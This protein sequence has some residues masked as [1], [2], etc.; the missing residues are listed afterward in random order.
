MNNIANI[1]AV[2]KVELDSELVGY[3]LTDNGIT[4]HVPLDT[5]NTEYQAILEWVA[6]GNTIAE[7]D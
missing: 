7:A 6:E 1:T 5:A 2:K 3:L 4:M